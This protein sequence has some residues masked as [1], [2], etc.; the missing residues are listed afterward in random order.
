MFPCA[1]FRCRR[2]NPDERWR[3][4]ERAY[5][6]DPTNQNLDR[7]NHLRHQSGLSEY[8]MCDD[9]HQI[10]PYGPACNVC[11]EVSVCIDCWST[12]DCGKHFACT[13]G[14]TPCRQQCMG[15]GEA[16]CP[17]CETHTCVECDRP[18]CQSCMGDYWIDDHQICSSCYESL[19][20]VGLRYNPYE[21]PDVRLRLAEKEYNDYPSWNTW[22]KYNRLRRQVGL[23]EIPIPTQEDGI[24]VLPGFTLRGKF[25]PPEP[26]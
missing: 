11:H 17:L 8:G 19:G 3:E 2:F 26:A 14:S 16:L 20:G 1:C 7:L 25:K 6:V 15:C 24:T 9:C 18:Y 12:E 22:E 5:Y 21:S 23:P 13:A 4:A 10:K